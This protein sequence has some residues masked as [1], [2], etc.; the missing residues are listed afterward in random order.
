MKGLLGRKL[1]MTQVFTTDGT[2]IPVTVVG[3]E[4]NVVLQKKTRETDGYVAIQLGVQD[5][6][7]QRANKPLV[8]HVT[9]ANTGPKQFIREIRSQEMFDLF[10]V[11]AEVKADLFS[12]GEKVDVSGTSK[13]KGFMGAVYRNNQATGPNSHGSGFHRGLGSLA[14]IG[15]N[16]GIINKGTAMAGHEGFLSTT[17]QNLEI[18]KVD[19]ENNALLIKGNIPGPKRG[20]VM[21]KTTVKSKKSVEARDLLDRTPIVEEELVET[22]VVEEVAEEV[23]ETVEEVVETPVE[24]VTPEVVAEETAVEEEKKED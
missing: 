22:A 24:A 4:P 21:I 16:N 9:K 18:I 14:T 7:I 10:E 23:V 11:G 1:G 17:N 15:R 3:V 20:F 8:G 13:G 5:K 2:L 12:A 19:T 6:K